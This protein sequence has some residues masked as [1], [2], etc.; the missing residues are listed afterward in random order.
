MLQCFFILIPGNESMLLKVRTI[1]YPLLIAE[2]ENLSCSSIG[3]NFV[4][5]YIWSPPFVGLF[6]ILWFLRELLTRSHPTLILNILTQSSIHHASSILVTFHS[7]FFSYFH[8]RFLS[9]TD[10]N[11]QEIYL[12]RGNWN[13]I[14]KINHWLIR[15]YQKMK[16]NIWLKPLENAEQNLSIQHT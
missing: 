5:G 4:L 12:L 8:Y 11:F 14:C 1:F 9:K 2:G 13:L 16:L 3:L 6:V 7:I 10:L 15:D